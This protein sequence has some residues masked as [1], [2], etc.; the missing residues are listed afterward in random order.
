MEHIFS[1]EEHFF[2]RACEKA[3]ITCP[4]TKE[5]AMERAGS[6]MVKT[7]FEQ[8]TPLKDLIAEM[9]PASYDNMVAWKCAYN[10]SRLNRLKKKLNY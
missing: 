8:Y 1:H 9:Y 5:A 10:A 2:V 4:I 7:D 6:L 3:G